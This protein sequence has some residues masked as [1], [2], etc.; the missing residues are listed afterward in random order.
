MA[1]W[2]G[3][4]I[5]ESMLRR[6]RV[7]IRE[8]IGPAQIAMIMVTVSITDPYPPCLGIIQRD[9]P[10]HRGGRGHFLIHVLPSSEHGLGT[11]HSGLQSIAPL[12]SA[13]FL[14]VP[15]PSTPLLC[16]REQQGAA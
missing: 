10:T 3:R 2:R 12:R 9:H 6:V 13:P 16:V 11:L 15:L 8:R 7:P 4:L 1:P 14:L 5:A